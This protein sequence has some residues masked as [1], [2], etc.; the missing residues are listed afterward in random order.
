[1]HKSN[2]LYANVRSAELKISNTGDGESI[3]TVLATEEPAIVFDYYSFAPIREVLL[4]SGVQLPESK[5][6]PMLD[7][8]M[9]GSSKNVIGSMRNLRVEETELVSDSVFSSAN[10][11]EEQK[12]KERHITDVS[13]GYRISE[14]DSIRLESGQDVDIDGK[15]YTND[16]SDGYDLVIR[17]TWRPDEG[18]IVPIGADERAKFR[19]MYIPDMVTPLEA[20]AHKNR[21][22]INHNKKDNDMPNE[23]KNGHN[24]PESDASQREAHQRE[25]EEA[26]REALEQGKRAEQERCINIRESV[27]IA[28]LPEEKKDELIRGYIDNGKTIEEVR[29]DLYKQVQD[30]VDHSSVPNVKITAEQ[31]EKFHRGVVEMFAVQAGIATKEEQENIRKSTIPHSL[32]GIARECLMNSDPAN[33]RKYATMDGDELFRES[34]KLANDE[35]TGRRESVNLGTGQLSSILMD[36]QNKVMGTAFDG[37]DSTWSQWCGTGSA[38]DFKTINI[39]SS[40]TFSDVREI[41]DGDAAYKGTLGDKYETASMSTYGNGVVIGRKVFVNDDLGM[42]NDIMQKMGQAHARGVEELVYKTWVGTALAGPQM[43]ETDGNGDTRYLFE[44]DANSSAETECNMLTSTGT[45]DE[46]ALRT[47]RARLR[48]LAVLSA[49]DNGMSKTR[50]TGLQPRYYLA[51][52]ENEETDIRYFSSTTLVMNT[53]ADDMANVSTAKRGITPIFSPTLQYYLD[54]SSYGNASNAFYIIADQNTGYTACRVYFLNGQQRPTL[55]RREMAAG[56]PLGIVFDGYFDYGVATPEWR[57][58]VCSDGK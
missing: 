7:S 34:V 49:D 9:R 50:Y 23:N 41:L 26:K 24:A 45:L 37:F 12:V 13:V 14:A 4:M 32:K 38:S 25:I 53:V 30:S 51:G 29:K 15:R 16:Y 52:I 17:K 2:E 6:V 56:E 48:K 3:R 47:A 21:S 36:A 57:A 11:E 33:V 42:I 27:S 54:D 19:S 58:A 10:K 5:Q 46:P 44:D 55:R 31:R 20:S 40:S 43:T 35:C 28:N 1:M 18:S 8:H 39:I 22:D